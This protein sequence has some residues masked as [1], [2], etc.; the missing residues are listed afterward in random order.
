MTRPGKPS[1]TGITGSG[2]GT[3]SEPE[4]AASDPGWANARINPLT[5]LALGSGQKRLDDLTVHIRQAEVA[6]LVREG[7][8]FVIEAEKVEGR[9]IQVVDVN[10]LL[11]DVEAELIGL[12]I[13]DAR[14]D[15]APGQPDG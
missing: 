5:N 3:S 4:P 12:P 11:D 15:P 10:G 2:W 8:P 9:R 14:L 7:Q 1:R 13:R 6:P